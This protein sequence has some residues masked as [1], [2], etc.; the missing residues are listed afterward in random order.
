MT[1]LSTELTRHHRAEPDRAGRLADRAV[2]SDICERTPPRAPPIRGAG[3]GWITAAVNSKA[4]ATSERLIPLK[5]LA[6]EA[7]VWLDRA[8]AAKDRARD[9]RISAGEIL[10]EAKDRVQLGEPGHSNWARWVRDNIKHSYRDANNCIALTNRATAVATCVTIPESPFKVDRLKRDIQ[11]L[12]LQDQ[13]ALADWLILNNKVQYDRFGNALDTLAARLRRILFRLTKE[14]NRKSS[15]NEQ[16]IY[17]ELSLLARSQTSGDNQSRIINL[18]FAVSQLVSDL[19]AASLCQA[20]L[21]E[22]RESYQNGVRELTAIVTEL[23]APVT[24]T[25]AAE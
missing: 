15:K 3:E 25:S 10:A 21:S 17:N 24:G 12:S 9:L 22:T 11:R 20:T 2:S 4:P 13:A 7:N 5:Q 8:K 14:I 23:S 18:Q 19:T 16:H 1:D 6:A